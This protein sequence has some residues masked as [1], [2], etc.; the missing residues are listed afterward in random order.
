MINADH[1]GPLPVSGNGVPS[2]ASD[3]VALVTLHWHRESAWAW[4]SDGEGPVSR[5][6]GF[7]RLADPTTL[8]A[9][10]AALG[11]RLLTVRE[12]P[13]GLVQAAIEIPLPVRRQHRGLDIEPMTA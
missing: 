1:G 13:G 9:R 3:D 6:A 11:W 8:P 10:I 2:A 4:M 12:R 5:F 7:V